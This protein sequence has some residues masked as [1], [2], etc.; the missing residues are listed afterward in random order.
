MMSR[1]SLAW[2]IAGWAAISWGGRILIVFDT[3]AGG[4]ERIRIAASVL[5][6]VAAVTALW[7]RRW[8][9]PAIFAY[10]G[11]TIVV[12]VRSMSTV[13]MEPHSTGFVAVHLLLAGISLTL[14]AVALVSLRRVR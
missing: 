2:A 6:A 3:G 13:L 4:W 5:V 14:A 9:V 11:V 12:W 8:E 1:T 7:L 10:T